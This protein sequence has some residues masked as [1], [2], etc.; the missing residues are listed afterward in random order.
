MEFIIG[1]VILGLFASNLILVRWIVTHSTS[2]R[3]PKVEQP[4]K[5]LAQFGGA[6]FGVRSK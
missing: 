6:P 2:F 1:I 3:A 4:K 5:E